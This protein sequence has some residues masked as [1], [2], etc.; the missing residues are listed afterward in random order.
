MTSKIHT[1]SDQLINQIAAGEVVEQPASV[2]KELLENA[3]DAGTTQVAITIDGGGVERISVVDNGC[4]MDVDDA[5]KAFERHATSKIATLHDLSQLHSLGFRGEALASIAAVSTVTLITKTSDASSAVRLQLSG[6]AIEKEEHVAAQTGTTITI[7]NL[8]FNTPARRKFLKT[9]RA[10]LRAIGEIVADFALIHPEIALTY[11][12][13]GTERMRLPS[14][15]SL[16]VRAQAVLGDAM[17]ARA[18]PVLFTQE[19]RI[20]TLQGEDRWEKITVTGLIG[21]PQHARAQRTLSYLF[22]NERPIE[23]NF[24]GFKIKEAYGALLDGKQYPLYLLH[25]TMDPSFVDVNVHPRKTQVKFQQPSA[26]ASLVFTAVQSTLQQHDVTYTLT[27]SVPTTSGFN[28]SDINTFTNPTAQASYATSFS[29]RPIF[30]EGLEQAML[31]S[32]SSPLY[33]QPLVQLFA[34]YIL[35]REGNDYVLVDQHAAQERVYYEQFLAEA[36]KSI[37]DVQTMMLP[38]TLQLSE[39]DFQLWQEHKDIFTSLGFQVEQFGAHNLII[40]AVPMFLH[41]YSAEPFVLAVLD[42]LSEERGQAITDAH[43]ERIIRNSCKKSIKA[44]D[45]LSSSEMQELLRDL[46]NCEQRYTCPHGR[47]TIIRMTLGDLE[48]MFKRR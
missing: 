14:T 20:Q 9:P 41:E 37:H 46:Y 13:D 30:G 22:V 12:I 31:L 38:E 32:D 8:F 45:Q 18:L 25:L 47:P 1:L 3:Y 6:G 7:D 10:E 16:T 35:A 43:R 5:H 48:T 39:Q 42:A 27:G 24:L 19:I 17:I 4:G 2:V 34:T 23:D 33:P 40:S 29:Q 36:K 11:T 21:L 15:N 44:N 26:I 28:T